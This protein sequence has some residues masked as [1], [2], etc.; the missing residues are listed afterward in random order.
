MDTET[1]QMLLL[2][3]F[4][5]AHGYLAAR[6]HGIGPGLANPK[7]TLKE[8]MSLT[9][10]R[11]F[12]K[13]TPEKMTTELLLKRSVIRQ[14]KDIFSEFRQRRDCNRYLVELNENI[15][16]R[17]P[18]DPLQATEEKSLFTF[19]E[20]NLNKTDCDLLHLK[21]VKGLDNNQLAAYFRKTPTAIKLQWFRLKPKIKMLIQKELV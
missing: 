15:S 10:E 21:F 3:Y 12:R 5:N 14:A 13:L 8:L 20:R 2:K 19:L 6:V 9:Q 1:L 18:E 4:V 16:K 7:L 11:C 17:T